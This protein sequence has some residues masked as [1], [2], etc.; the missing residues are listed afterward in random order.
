M[1]I[2]GKLKTLAFTIGTSFSY[3]NL[4]S[5]LSVLVK[6]GTE[7]LAKGLGFTEAPQLVCT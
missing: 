5:I 3:S 7:M 2:D 1:K 4:A 6:D